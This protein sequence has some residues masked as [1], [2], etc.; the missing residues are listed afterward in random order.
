MLVKGDPGGKLIIIN[1]LSESCYLAR[2]NINFIPYQMYAPC[3]PNMFGLSDFF[4]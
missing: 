3:D 2:L 4:R 1:N